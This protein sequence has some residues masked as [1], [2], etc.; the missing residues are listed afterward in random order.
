[1]SSDTSP[2]DGQQAAGAIPT[3]ATIT[4]RQQASRQAFGAMLLNWRRRCGW[5][6][7][8]AS[9]WAEAIGQ[10]KLVISPGNLSVIEQGKAGELRQKCFWQLW[11]LNR[12]IARREWGSGLEPTVAEKLRSAI[13]LGDPACPLWGPVEF[14]ACYC[15][16]RPVPAAFRV[17]PPPVISQRQ[18]TELSARWRRQLHAAVAQRHIEPSAAIE[19]LT[20]RATS[21]QRSRF[22][23]VLTGF[24]DYSSTELSAL[25]QA[26]GQYLPECWLAQWQQAAGIP[27]LPRPPAAERSS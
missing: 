23:A 2:P 5:S 26:D 10:P 7:Y 15:G 22:F 4:G 16:L 21:S 27:D 9:S 18:A 24:G 20:A 1:V 25:W 13:P 12:R 19:Q 3:L 14:W 17:T 6:Q 8:T 11:E